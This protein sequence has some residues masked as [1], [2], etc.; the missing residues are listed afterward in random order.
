MSW[1]ALYCVIVSGFRSLAG[2]KNATLRSW[3][4]KRNP[5]L[6][7]HSV[8]RS[9]R[10]LSKVC[11]TW[12]SVFAPCRLAAFAHSSG[13]VDLMKLVTSSGNMAVS[14]FHPDLSAFCHPLSR[15]MDSTAF[16]KARSV[17]CDVMRLL[18][19]FSGGARFSNVDLPGDC[20]V[21][22][23]GSVFAEPLDGGA[24]AL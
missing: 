20:G 1:L 23:C 17:V 4:P 9:F 7:T 13:W 15:S 14:T 10:V 5:C 21:D 3:P 18:R 8:P 22:E 12:L 16:S 2:L 24:C 11:S 6:S 19:G